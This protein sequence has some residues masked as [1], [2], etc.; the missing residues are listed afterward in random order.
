MDSPI[1]ELCKS[2]DY[3]RAEL[4][5]CREAMGMKGTDLDRLA[6]VVGLLYCHCSDKLQ[7]IVLSTLDEIHLRSALLIICNKH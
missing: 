3:V 7:T 1:R 5:R 2:D 4:V 6:G